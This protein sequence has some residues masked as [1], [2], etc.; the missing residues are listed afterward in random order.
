ML[1]IGDYDTDQR[2]QAVSV[3]AIL[4]VGL[5][6]VLLFVLEHKHFTMREAHLLLYTIG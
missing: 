1:R 6:V 3:Y 5:R 2:W 4:Q